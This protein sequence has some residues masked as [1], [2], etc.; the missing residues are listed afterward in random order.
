VNTSTKKTTSTDVLERGSKRPTVGGMLEVLE[1]LECQE[2]MYA[3]LLCEEGH[4]R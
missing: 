3:F 2:Y 4:T 1:V